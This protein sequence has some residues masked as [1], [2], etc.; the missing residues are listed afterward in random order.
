MTGPRVPEAAA[1]GFSRVATEYERARR[2]YPRDLIDQVAATVGI[3]PGRTVVDLAAGT[4][5]LTRILV[6]S[7]CDLV[8]IEP[9]AEMRAQLIEVLSDVRVIGG[10][11]EAIPLPD[12]SVDVVTVAQAFHWFDTTAAL[13][14]LAR[15][16]RPG[17][18]LVLVWNERSEG[19]WMVELQDLADRLSGGARYRGAAWRPPVEADNR[20]GPLQ[21]K[22]VTVVEHA[23][24]EWI[25]D[26]MAT[27]SWI[28]SKDA[29]TRAEILTG[30]R[31]FLA[32]HRDTAGRDELVHDHPCIAYWCQRR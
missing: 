9:V 24:A 27:R 15:V 22:T 14:E 21:Q 13:D 30:L 10:T 29:E 11:A 7:G 12:G 25:V 19:G 28:A 26:S 4:G 6:G 1:V 18:W 20:F 32:Q 3:G 16:I 8:A 2:G 23:T 17:G 5:K 31:E